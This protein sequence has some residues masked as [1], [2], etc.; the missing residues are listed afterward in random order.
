MLLF[1]VFASNKKSFFS[2]SIVVQEDLC[3]SILLALEIFLVLVLRMGS[4]QPPCQRRRLR[5]PGAARPQR[6]HVSE[7]EARQE[8]HG[9]RDEHSW[10]KK[11][12]EQRQKPEEGALAKGETQTGPSRE[13]VS[14]GGGARGGLGGAL[15][16]PEDRV[17]LSRVVEL[18]VRCADGLDGITVVVVF[19]EKS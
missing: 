17:L 4:A 14:L 7:V 5:R 1:V 15:F 8:H 10:A 12:E 9:G 13:R 3:R 18:A 19:W 16:S 6:D 11:P 2:L